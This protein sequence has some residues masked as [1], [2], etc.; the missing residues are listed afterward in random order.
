MQRPGYILLSNGLFCCSLVLKVILF[1]RFY[2]VL[3]AVFKV[4]LL[5]H[6]QQYSTVEPPLSG[7][8]LEASYQ[9]PENNVS[10]ILKYYPYLL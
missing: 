8:L 4:I 3:S 1:D 5:R 9:S 10:K 2:Y 7:C 6:L